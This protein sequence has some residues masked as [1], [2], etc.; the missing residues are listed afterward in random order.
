MALILHIYK[1]KTQD[2]SIIENYRAVTLINCTCKGYEDI[3]C[4]RITNHLEGLKGIARGHRAR[5][6]MSNEELV[7]TLTSAARARHQH[8]GAGTY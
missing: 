8:S 4:Q 6:H 7:H 2:S 3:L 5:R 1:Q